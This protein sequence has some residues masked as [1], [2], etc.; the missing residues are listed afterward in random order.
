VRKILVLA[1]Q[2]LAGARLVQTLK[3]RAAQE[4][5]KFFIVV[6]Q[7]R[8]RH[9]NIIYDEAV[10]T[11]AQVRVDRGV[12]VLSRAGLDAQGEVGDEDPFLAAMD[13]VR[14]HDVD[15]IIVSTLPATA[16]GWMRR[17]LPERLQHESGL[18]VEHVVVDLDREELQFHGTLVMANQTVAGDALIEHLKRKASGD[19][20][21]RY[22]VLVPQDSGDGQACDRARARMEKLLESLHAED[23]PAVGMIGD[24]DPYT[25]AMNAVDFFHLHDIV[26]ST[27][28]SNRSEWLKDN[29]IERVEKGTGKPVEHVE[30]TVDEPAPA[31]A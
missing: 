5:T 6:P 10:R 28:P 4:E 29:L 24:P 30:S 17:D 12:E 26:I 23:I 9:G 18:P 3:D 7:T 22:I 8:P 21:Q 11:M 25:A 27:L 15:E 1:N 16:S 14:E 2:T 31:G 20:E 13:A 19:V